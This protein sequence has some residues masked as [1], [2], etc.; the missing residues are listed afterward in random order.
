MNIEAIHMNLNEQLAKLSEAVAEVKKDS[1]DEAIRVDR[2]IALLSQEN[3]AI[4]Q[5]IADLQITA[6][7]LRSFHADQSSTPVVSGEPA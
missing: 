4:S 6:E 3:P 1:D 7:K 2:V 5:A